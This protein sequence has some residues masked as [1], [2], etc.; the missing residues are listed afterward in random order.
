[1][2]REQRDIRHLLEGAFWATSVVLGVE[3]YRTYRANRGHEPQDDP[4]IVCAKCGESHGIREFLDPVVTCSCAAPSD[5]Q[6]G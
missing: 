3:A 6:T 2:A 4:A 5:Q 1:M